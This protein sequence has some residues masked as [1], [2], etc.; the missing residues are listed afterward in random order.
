[1]LLSANQQLNVQTNVHITFI[2]SLKDEVRQAGIVDTWDLPESGFEALVQVM[3][4]KSTKWREKARRIVLVATDD[5]PHLV[6]QTRIQM[7]HLA[8][9]LLI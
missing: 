8:M 1:M 9:R 6:I 4:C 7:K 5:Y 3:V 2:R